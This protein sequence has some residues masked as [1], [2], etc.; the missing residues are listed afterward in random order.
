MKDKSLQN[1]HQR[2]M[3]KID[4]LLEKEAMHYQLSPKDKSI[5]SKEMKEREL[6]QNKV[7]GEP[8]LS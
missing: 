3:T 8:P 1:D 4:G 7:K 6:L 5:F 2:Y